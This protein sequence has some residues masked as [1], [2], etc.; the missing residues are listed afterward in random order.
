MPFYVA[1]TANTTEVI[2][3]GVTNNGATYSSSGNY[4]YAGFTHVICDLDTAAG[5][6]SEG[7]TQILF[8]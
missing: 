3:S 2:A 4:S 6:T 1:T 8:I 7:L 5:G